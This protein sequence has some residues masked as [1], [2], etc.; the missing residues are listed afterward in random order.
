MLDER[1]RLGIDVRDEMWNGVVHMVP[2]PKDEHQG[3]SGDLYYVLYPLAKRRGLVP[4]METGLFDTD[5]NYRVPDQLY[6]RPEHGSERGAERAELVVEVRSPNDDTY[7][8]LDFYAAAG[9]RE[10][11]VLHPDDRRAE[12][13]RLVDGRLLPVSAANGV[14]ESDVLGVGLAT[15]QGML[16]ITWSDGSADI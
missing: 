6:R 3:L 5:D 13:F 12:L 9:V 11:L 1:R 2:P 10:V 7:R 16:R 14:V 4:R 15:V 8:K